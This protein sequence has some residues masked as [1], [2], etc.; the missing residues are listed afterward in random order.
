MCLN[1]K[2]SGKHIRGIHNLM[3]TMMPIVFYLSDHELTKL[4]CINTACLVQRL[5][6]MLGRTLSITWPKS[7]LRAFR[8]YMLQVINKRIKNPNH[9]LFEF[10]QEIGHYLEN[11]VLI[12]SSFLP[13]DSQTSILPIKR[14]A[15]QYTVG[16][17]S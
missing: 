13:I 7:T 4:N 15:M 17:L 16:P 11:Y 10:L 6:C 3:G 12:L 8:K 1:L 9:K 2:T 14:Y 5:Q